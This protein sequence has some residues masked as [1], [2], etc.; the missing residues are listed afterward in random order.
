MNTDKKKEVVEKSEKIASLILRTLAIVGL[1]SVLALS[2]WVLIR[3]IS[4][5]PAARDSMAAT[6]ARVTQV[7]QGS[8]DESLNFALMTRLFAVHEEA[9][10]SWEYEGD[11]QTIFS[12]LYHCGTDASLSV[13]KDGEWLALECGTSVETSYKSV[14]V[15]PQAQN[16]P[17]DVRIT[18]ET[19]TLIDSTIISIIAKSDDGSEGQPETL[20]QEDGALPEVTV[21]KEEPT[22]VTAEE[23]K[24]TEHA[25]QTTT[26]VSQPTAVVAPTQPTPADLAI[27]IT[28]TG[29]LVPIDGENVFFP[30]SPIPSDRM[31]GVTFTVTNIGGSTSDIWKFKAQLP[32]ENDASYVYESP[33]QIPLAPGM[34]I[35]FTLGFDQVRKGA[36]GVIYIEL[37][38]QDT[39]DNPLNNTARAPITITQ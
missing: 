25:P 4:Y 14:L 27:A 35:Q 3:G 31:A 34:Q 21:P 18:V 36:E 37:L 29:V 6:I 22:T 2:A 39:S 24:K 28:G 13:M 38:P 16:L 10:I 1:I 30:I 33:L 5:F 12:F 15:T 20:A 17:T 23:P 11:P 8:Q 26:T 32:T 9:V 7:F 19:P